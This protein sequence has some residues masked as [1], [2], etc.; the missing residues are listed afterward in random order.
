MEDGRPDPGGLALRLIGAGALA[1]LA[2]NAALA[3]SAVAAAVAALAGAGLAVG[4]ARLR[5]LARRLPT[6]GRARA[7][8]TG[9][10]G[11]NLDAVA[12]AVI[13]RRGGSEDKSETRR[14]TPR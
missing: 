12:A 11:L 10:P 13:H 3:G 8:L 9:R 6:L 4:A 7:Y 14:G 1:A 2:V 5:R